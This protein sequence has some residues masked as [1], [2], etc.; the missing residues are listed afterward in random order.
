MR[1]VFVFEYLTAGGLA[2]EDPAVAETLLPM[3]LAMRD[4]MVGDLLAAGAVQVSAASQAPAPPPPAG[5]TACARPAG[6][7]WP[8]WVARQ[9]ARH[10]AVWL[11]APETGGLLAQLQQ[12][13]P[14]AQWL[15]CE[16]PAIAL[17]ARK[18][19]TLARLAAFGLKTPLAWSAQATRWVV[20]PDDGAGGVATQVFDSLAAAHAAQCGAAHGER[21]LE[22]WVDGPALSLS[23]LCGPAGTELLSINRQHIRIGAGG[24][25][26]YEGVSHGAMAVDSPRGVALAALAARIGQAVPGLRGFVGVDLVWHETL[27]PVVI[28]INPRLTCAYVGLSARLG[29][30][31]A[32]EMLGRPRLNRQPDTRHARA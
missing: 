23:L 1:R 28:E 11:V 32:A 10:D 20:K 22:P 13:V 3:G 17:A 26:A 29:R 8:D 27:G 14:A 6:M 16:A 2:E 31:L 7:A 12:A 21:T 9:A 18:R 19:A 15:G 25:L 4:A 30:N 5:A 24:R